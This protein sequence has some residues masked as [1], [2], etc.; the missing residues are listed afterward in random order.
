MCSITETYHTIQD[1][2]AKNKI[3]MKMSVVQLGET[4]P[5]MLQC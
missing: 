2:D 4:F 3:L 5:K 1:L